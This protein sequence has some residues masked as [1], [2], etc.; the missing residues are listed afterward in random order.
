MEPSLPPDT[1]AALLLAQMTREEN[2]DMA[3]SEPC[4]L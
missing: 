4:G 1:R 3:T 2:T